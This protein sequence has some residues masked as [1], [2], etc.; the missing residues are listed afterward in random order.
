MAEIF[1]FQNGEFSGEDERE[2]ERAE[3]RMRLREKEMELRVK[4]L[5]LQRM[6]RT[7]RRDEVSF[8][9]ELRGH[10]PLFGLD[11]DPRIKVRIADQIQNA[12]GV[13]YRQPSNPLRLNHQ[14]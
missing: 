8:L 9:V 1:N 7:D 14:P 11:Q 12:V 13:Q 5:D 4:E 10:L 2:L 6:E 3:R